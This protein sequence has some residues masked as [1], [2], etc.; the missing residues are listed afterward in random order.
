MPKF[1]SLDWCI[2]QFTAYQPIVL[3]RLT[4]ESK[5]FPIDWLGYE[6][7]PK[8]IDWL[9]SPLIGGTNQCNQVYG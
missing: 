8:M 1:R 7:K 4:R 6:Y 5:V 3:D 2:G 9:V